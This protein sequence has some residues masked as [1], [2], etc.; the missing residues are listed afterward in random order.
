MTPFEKLGRL[1]RPEDQS[2]ARTIKREGRWPLLPQK[3]RAATILGVPAKRSREM[4][5]YAAGSAAL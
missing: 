4:A 5:N 3:R 1:C 2:V